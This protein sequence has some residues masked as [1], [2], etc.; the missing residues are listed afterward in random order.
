MGSYAPDTLLF[1][2][3]QSPLWLAY[4][5]QIAARHLKTKTHLHYTP[6]LYCSGDTVENTCSLQHGGIF[7]RLAVVIP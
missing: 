2:Q 7:C 6:H 3:E 1:E 4:G 5:V